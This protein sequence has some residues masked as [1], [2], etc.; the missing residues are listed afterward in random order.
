MSTQHA[1]PGPG[2]TR[3]G[4]GSARAR[5]IAIVI[6]LLA[7]V[8]VGASGRSSPPSPVDL[9]VSP[10]VTPAVAFATPTSAPSG[11][12]SP[13]TTAPT[14]SRD[15]LADD[16]FA[17]LVYAAGRDRPYLEV[18]DYAG[19]DLLHAD[20]RLAFPDPPADA[21]I[22]LVQLWTREE[23]APSFVSI[24]SFSL[25]VESLRTETRA[26]VT[27][28]EA[29]SPAQPRRRDLPRLLQ[30]GYRLS[31]QVEPQGEQALLSIDVSLAGPRLD[32]VFGD[33]R[34]VGR[35]VDGLQ[36]PHSLTGI[37]PSGRTST[38][39]PPAASTS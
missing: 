25:P 26:P 2:T 13:P 16:A 11:S 19:P 29:E 30:E 33:D 38:I 14:R 35:G 9:A 6:V 22:E 17:V 7:V 28:I 8:W 32:P 5:A 10:A 21:R 3:I 1:G 39:S 20:V 18:L 12:P 27:L 24:S 37:G 23:D 31:V 15:P 36:A 34:L 4:S